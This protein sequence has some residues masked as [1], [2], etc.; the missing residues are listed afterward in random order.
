MVAKVLLILTSH[1]ELGSSGKPTGFWFEELAAPYYAF[2]EAGLNVDLASLK[3][4]DAKPDP[5]SVDK[6][7]VVQRFRSD[8]LAMGKLRA[9]RALSEIRAEEY[10]AFF[11]VGGHGVMWD[12]ADSPV[13]TALLGRA[14]DLGK[15]VAAVCHGPA[16]LVNVKL[17]DG[18]PL[19]KGRRVASF[20][21]AEEQAAHLDAI[22]PFM[23]ESKLK[24]LGGRYEH[25]PMWTSF[26][27]RDGR[28]VTGQNP[29]SSLAV[30]RETVAALLP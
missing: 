23:L 22:V 18:A 12:L 26:V 9:A 30:A 28:L 16:A 6:D 24:S 20:S 15:V 5:S 10:D 13:N 8:P 25:G 21:N 2:L 27:V 29:Q 3:G 14:F 4:G 7:A 19:V 11:V 17:K 1:T